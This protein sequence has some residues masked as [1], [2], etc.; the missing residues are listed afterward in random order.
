[1]ERNQTGSDMDTDRVEC[2]NE[3]DQ[4]KV[5]EK[6]AEEMEWPCSV[7]GENIIELV[8]K[9]KEVTIT[10]EN[11]HFGK[12]RGEKKQDTERT[13]RKISKQD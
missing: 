1:M 13:E 9:E 7:C 8:Q 2:A 5:E 6:L 11:V 3:K 4:E 12:G 10:Y